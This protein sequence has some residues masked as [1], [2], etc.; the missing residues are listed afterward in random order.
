MLATMDITLNE[1]ELFK[2]RVN[3][4]N[5]GDVAP[6]SDLED[7]VIPPHIPQ[8]IIFTKFIKFV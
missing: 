1:I 6:E 8:V 7:N 5:Y 2:S 4:E 3:P